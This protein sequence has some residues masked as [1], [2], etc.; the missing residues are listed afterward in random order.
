MAADPTPKSSNKAEP[1]ADP[2]PPG[3]D[4]GG[5][6][7]PLGQKTKT[8]IDD[9][10][11]E[12]KTAADFIAEG[13]VDDVGQGSRLA[14]QDTSTGSQAKDSSMEAEEQSPDQAPVVTAEVNPAVDE[15]EAQDLTGDEGVIKRLREAGTGEL[16]PKG[17]KVTVEYTG[18]LSDDSI[19]DTSKRR[20]K[21][22]TF[23]LGEGKVI[24]GWEV[25]IATMKVGESADFT[26]APSY[27]YGR[28]GM[29]PVIPSNSTLTFSVKVLSA[30]LS[31][32]DSLMTDGMRNV[33]E[34]NQDVARTPEQI[35]RDYELRMAQRDNTKKPFFERFY[36]V[37]PFASQTGQR[38]PWW[39]NPAI[40]FSIAFIGVGLSFYIVLKSGAIHM[41][42][43]ADP[44][45][46][47][48][49]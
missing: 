6:P 36:F 38:P 35:N 26:I 16:L 1:N 7:R 47:G 48:P 21:G 25:G 2:E 5:G 15:D 40:T 29:P 27:A 12:R 14:T 17:T 46:P 44:V 31:S 8:S 11:F 10:I 19:F 9:L 30:D 42:Y 43:V 39:L 28:R 22:F 13:V 3:A 32:A 33:S 18:R 23:T 4:G 20:G 24:R 45:D 37:S 49:F 41:G 34:F